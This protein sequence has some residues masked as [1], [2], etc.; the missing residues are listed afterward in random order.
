MK[1]LK[2]VLFLIPFIPTY[3]FGQ[4]EDSAHDPYKICARVDVPLIVV[5]AGT[6][7]LGLNRLNDKSPLD[8]V[9]IVSLNRNDISKFD[10]NATYTHRHA[11]LN[12]YSDIALYSAFASP[13]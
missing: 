3:L 4:P 10:R 5:G 1:K 9:E 6:A 13:L 8:S 12:T 11:Q 7:Y 2:T